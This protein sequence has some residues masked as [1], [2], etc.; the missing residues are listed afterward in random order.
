MRLPVLIFDIE[1][2]TDLKAGA[3]LYNLDLP[4]DELEQAL[5]KLRRQ[6][7]G[8]DFQRLPLHEIVC[9]SGLWVDEHG[10]RLFSF[11]Q[12]QYAEAEILRKFLSIFEKR[13]PTLVSWNGSQFDLPVILFRTMYHGLSAPSLFDQGEIDIQKRYNNYQNRYH[14]RHVDL[15]DVMAMFNGRNFQKLDDA[16]Q[17]LG[18][19]G[20][21]AEGYRVPEQ[22]Q[23]G[24]WLE[25]SQH[26]EGDVLNTWLIY[27]RWLL[28]KGQ[29]LAEDHRFWIQSTIAYLS[30]QP[31]QADFVRLWQ[32]SSQHTEFTS[33]YI[34]PTVRD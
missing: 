11:S 7:A 5:I 4:D 13:H 14:H 22:V 23:H 21:R 2:L 18:Y 28:L 34:F 9:I 3:H 24:E 10:M 30:Q 17:L 33:H 19:P 8:T 26:C 27:L 25:L 15:M 32:D 29:L 16:A 12:E 1:T 6:E 20:K 31:Q